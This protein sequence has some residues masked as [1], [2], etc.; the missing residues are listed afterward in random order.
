MR[1]WFLLLLAAL[2]WAGCGGSEDQFFGQPV[3]ASVQVNARLTGV[4]GAYFPGHQTGSNDRGVEIQLDR[5]DPKGFILRGNG[6]AP[7][8]VEVTRDGET[9]RI[10]L[11]DR[12]DST[13]QSVI[14]GTLLDATT[15]RGHFVNASRG[16]AFSVDLKRHPD[17]DRF[18]SPDLLT[19]SP[20]KAPGS[21]EVLTITATGEDSQLYLIQVWPGNPGYY[22]MSAPFRSVGYCTIQPLNWFA[23]YSNFELTEPH[24]KLNRG[25]LF[26]KLDD[27]SKVGYDPLPLAGSGDGSYIDS[28]PNGDNSAPTATHL[29]NFTFQVTPGPAATQYKTYGEPY[30][31]ANVF[32][33]YN[34]RFPAVTRSVADYLKD[35]GY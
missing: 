23:S 15:L 6:P 1:R 31:P 22:H 29:T 33:F 21:V 24:L 12:H 25:S 28:Y 10:V 16:E 18:P 20:V 19:Q 2:L 5:Q 8:A 26:V 14:T 35:Y 13:D 4:W 30:D 3:P 7:Q 17:S 27:W 32:R 34:A 9:V 11:T